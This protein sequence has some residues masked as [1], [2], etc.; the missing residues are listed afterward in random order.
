MWTKN[1]NYVNLERIA[2]IFEFW[3]LSFECGL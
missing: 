3:V 2:G 1:K